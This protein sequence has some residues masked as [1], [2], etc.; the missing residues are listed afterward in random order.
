MKIKNILCLFLLA[1]IAIMLPICAVDKELKKQKRQAFFN[2]NPDIFQGLKVIYDLYRDDNYINKKRPFG[3]IYFPAE[4]RQMIIGAIIGNARSDENGQDL[5]NAL[6]C[7]H[8]DINQVNQLLKKR[9][10]NTNVQ[11]KYGETALFKSAR[12]NFPKIVQILLQKNANPNLQRRYG[13]TPLHEAATNNHQ[14][15]VQILLQK[16]ANTN[17]QDK[18]G[19]TPLHR[20]IINNCPEI[21]KMLLHKGANTNLHDTYGKTALECAIRRGIPEIIQMLNDA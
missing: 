13:A 7:Y 9:Y 17:L 12:N 8:C 16:D 11:D 3:T 5:L 19:R 4:L 10:I 18:Y 2:S 21:V 1:N 6:K 14:E 15:I 20:A